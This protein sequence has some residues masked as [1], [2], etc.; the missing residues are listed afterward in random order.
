MANKT[1]IMI[2]RKR[3][4]FKQLEVTDELKLSF[5]NQ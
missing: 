4:Y 3:S 5:H 1:E 2:A